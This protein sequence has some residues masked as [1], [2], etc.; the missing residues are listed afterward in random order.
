MKTILVIFSQEKL[1]KSEHQTM[2][3]YSFNTKANLKVGDRLITEMY[4]TPIQVVEVLDKGYKY[5]NKGTGELSSKRVANS[6]QLEIREIRVHDDGHKATEYVEA[7]R[8]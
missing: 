8:E 4:S 3:R 7:Y 2:K 5:Y 6:M 1:S